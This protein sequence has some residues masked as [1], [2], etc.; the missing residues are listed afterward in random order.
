MHGSRRSS[1]VDGEQGSA[2][3]IALLVLTVIGAITAASLSYLR[4]S[5]AGANSATHPSRTSGT[6][7]DN[8]METAIAYLHAHPETGRALGLTCPAATL[9]F[10]GDS[11][12]V[13][14]AMCPQAGSLVPTNTALAK[15]L[16]LGTSAAEAGITASAPGDLV[17]YGDVFSNAAITA[18]GA[19][20]LVDHQ[21]RVWARR[22][23]TGTIAVD[24]NGV[25][26]VCNLGGA[27]P[28][29]GVDPVYV[30]AVSSA[31]GNGIGSCA[32]GV[33][34]IG[35]GSYTLAQLNA[36]VG[37]CTTV[38]FEPGVFYFNF[39][40]TPWNATGLKIIGGTP[41]GGPLP[42]VPF[43]GGCNPTAPGSQLIF[44]N[45]SRI[46]LSGG[47][48][49]DVCGLD[50]IE[51]ATTVKLAMV[52]LR[53]NTGGMQAESGCITQVNG[54]AVLQGTGAGTGVNISGTVYMPRAKLDLQPSGGSYAITDAAVLRALNI[55]PATPSPAVVVGT[56]FAPRSPGDIV[57]TA[58]IAGVNWLAARVIL[59]AGAN[60]VPTIAD[61]VIDH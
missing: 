2:L 26:P 61:W 15:L 56:S 48:T 8:A 31:P 60:P 18:N 25:A 52:G 53:A 49:L 7:A 19:G 14:V 12:T 22:A 3:I 51:G 44:G 9:T 10:P 33:A 29:V 43:P 16:T 42:A 5:L 46:V 50:T 23:C 32:A 38:W 34:T 39:G 17:V 35:P 36:A 54:C 1:P 21:G 20:R 55:A 6:S 4:T 41:T 58:S 47:S 28:A 40:N 59:P 37:G 24:T 13:T 45:S 30:A 27:V 11:G 57:L